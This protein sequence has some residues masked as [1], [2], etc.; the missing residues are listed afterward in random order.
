[1]KINFN[2]NLFFQKISEFL[3]RRNLLIIFLPYTI[4]SSIES[5]YY[6]Q[7]IFLISLLFFFITDLILNKVNIKFIDYL[8]VN[9]ISYLLYS[10]IIFKDTSYT[11]HQL[12]F[13]VFSFIFLIFFGSIFFFIIYIYNNF[14][15][16]NVVILIFGFLQFF[17]PKK[18]NSREEIFQ[19]Y[20]LTSKIIN[21]EEDVKSELPVILIIVD[22]LTSGQE[23]FKITNDKKDLQFD[24]FLRAKNYIIKPNFASK[25]TWTQYSLSSLFNFNFHESDT[26]KKI[27]ILKNSFAYR[28]DF[29]FLTSE[30]SLVD[31][32]K[33]H[34]IK[35]FS[36]GLI[37]FKGGELTNDFVI[38]L[39]GKEN[40]N[41]EIEMLKNYKLFQSFFHKS[42]INFID[43]RF[44]DGTPYLYDMNRKNTLDLLKDV[45]L[46]N[47][48]FY[49]FH[50]FAP[51]APFSYFEEFEYKKEYEKL[52]KNMRFKIHVK[53]RNFMMDKLS[54]ALNMEK[55]KS[56]RIII[57][58]DHG[59]R[60]SI[61][62][63]NNTMGA[64]KGYDNRT[65]SNY[66]S[67]QDLGSLIFNSFKTQ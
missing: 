3:S 4:L 2:K 34:K 13:T 25:S 12:N 55:F 59:I 38:N 50:Y 31:S 33:N 65:L 36:Y 21:Q 19:K 51:H 17:T 42:V 56:A 11:F 57:A 8:T 29:R 6:Y 28:D 27:E 67:V 64:F 7:N 20:N 66:N 43:Q 58:G 40:F 24:R 52:E 44:F 53:Y 60:E 22:G 47:N 41:F 46:E 61:I 16:F 1:M 63:E 15:F 37:P 49:Y 23:I 14:K 54:E 10:L 18:S 30:N 26:I 32:L 39:W 62:D 45:K 9:L 48:S 5:D 35:S